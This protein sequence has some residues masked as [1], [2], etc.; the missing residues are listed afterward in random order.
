MPVSHDRCTR[1]TQSLDGALAI[2]KVSSNV[3]THSVVQ[4][5]QQLCTG[6][7]MLR[8]IAIHLFEE[9]ASRLQVCDG[10]EST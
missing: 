6:V 3:S 8:A 4:G 7:V 2:A 9:R 5:L 10:H 1:H